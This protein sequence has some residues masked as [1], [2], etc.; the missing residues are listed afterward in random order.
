MAISMSY[1][2]KCM[3]WAI[4]VNFCEEKLAAQ[5]MKIINLILD[6]KSL[7]YLVIHGNLQVFLEFY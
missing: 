1:E 2:M 5:K 3:L 6:E 4:R 7:N